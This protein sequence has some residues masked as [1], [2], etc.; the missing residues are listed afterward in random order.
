MNSGLVLLDIFSYSCMNCLRSLQ[1]IKKIDRIYKKH[2]LKIVLVHPP[3]W[4]FEKNINNVLSGMKKSNINFP[5][6]VDN[7]KKIIKKFKI[8]FWPTQILLKDGKVVYKHIGE[9]NYS[10]L[11]DSI[12]KI[13][14]IKRIR[15]FKKEPKFSK[16]PT[17]Y[18]GKGK[19]G[20]ISKTIYH[21]KFGT[22]FISGKWVQK[23]EFLQSKGIG[24]LTLLIKGSV[25]NFVAESKSQK[26]VNV[27]ISVDGK[28]IKNIK[29]KNPGLYNIA[30]LSGTKER[31]LTLNANKNL[32]VYSFSFQ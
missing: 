11:E 21:E 31:K 2:G 8:R 25:I 16:F 1:S 5:L 23:E 4:Y 24:S 22:V 20:N 27:K 14:K 32:A 13:L 26:P 18:L 3:E 7:N 9:G 10:K 15:Y 17:I 30:R 29:A 12:I 6:I 28:F 19:N